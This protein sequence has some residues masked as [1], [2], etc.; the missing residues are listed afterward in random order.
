M[1]STCPYLQAV[2]K[3]TEPPGLWPS[4]RYR[5]VA[6][7]Q[8]RVVAPRAQAYFC[9]TEQHLDCPFFTASTDAPAEPDALT[10]IPLQPEPG[11]LPG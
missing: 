10:E 2:G 1:E 7:T 3:S 9:L 8:R 4:H 11:P 5:C 6:G